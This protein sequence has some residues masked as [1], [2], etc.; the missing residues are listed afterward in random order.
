VDV[1]SF[2]LAD[3]QVCIAAFVRRLVLEDPANCL[4]LRQEDYRMYTVP[5]LTIGEDSRSFL[6][7]GSEV[8]RLGSGRQQADL[9][10]LLPPVPP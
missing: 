5:V 8:N 7:A 2:R 10:H 9:D 1:L 6:E 4:A 3:W